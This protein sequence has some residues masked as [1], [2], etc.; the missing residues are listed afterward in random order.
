MVFPVARERYGWDHGNYSKYMTFVASIGLLGKLVVL[1][2]LLKLTKSRMNGEAGPALHHLP[3]PDPSP[4]CPIALYLTP[5]LKS[6]HHSTTP[7]RHPPSHPSHL[8]I[9][10]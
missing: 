3:S 6:H 7:P 4:F 5:Y 9:H 8:S 1:P 10:P 2:V